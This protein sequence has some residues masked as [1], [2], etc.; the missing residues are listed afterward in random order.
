M[1]EEITGQPLGEQVAPEETQETPQVGVGEPAPEGDKFAGKPE[2]DV[3][4]AYEEAQKVIG[5]Q[6]SEL[7]QTKAELEQTRQAVAQMQQQ[8]AQMM[9]Q[10]QQGQTRPQTQPEPEPAT[11]WDWDNPDKSASSIARQEAQTILRQELGQ[12]YRAMRSEIAVTNAQ[13]A[14]DRAKGTFRDVFSDPQIEARTKAFIMEGIRSGQL[15]PT[16][17]EDP[18]NWA[19]VAYVLKGEAT[20]YGS[21]VTSVNPVS[22]TPTDSP[23]AIKSRS[24]EKP[25]ELDDYA[26]TMIRKFGGDPEKVK[27]KIRKESK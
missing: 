10:L 15:N 27:Q 2:A 13:N 1:P 12:F 26:R 4:K 23:N 17:A 25:V 20:G 21:G 24:T 7:G 5:R 18:M 3:R 16:V 9:A 19:R 8:Y 11:K 6:G 14:L 22:P